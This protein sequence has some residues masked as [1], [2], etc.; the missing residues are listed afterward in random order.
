[1]PG[2]NTLL[3]FLIRV[4]G[5][6]DHEF[7]GIEEGKNGEILLPELECLAYPNPFNSMVCVEYHSEDAENVKLE[8]F[9]LSGRLVNIVFD[10][11]CNPGLNRHYYSPSPETP[12][13]LYT[14]R[15]TTANAFNTGRLLYLK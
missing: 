14:Y 7:T 1:M 5:W 10:G 2:K 12:S 8:I 6:F 13:G 9:D 4:L 15:V 11:V 3:Q